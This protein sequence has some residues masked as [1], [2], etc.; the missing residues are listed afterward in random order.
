MSSVHKRVDLSTQGFDSISFGMYFLNV[1]RFFAFHICYF[2]GSSFSRILS[3]QA[4][5]CG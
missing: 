5:L 3:L 4:A 2:V 1:D